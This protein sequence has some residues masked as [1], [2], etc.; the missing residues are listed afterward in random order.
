MRHKADELNDEEMDKQ[1]RNK[2]DKIDNA[3]VEGDCN[4]HQLKIFEKRISAG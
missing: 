4:C 2:N 3:I 1:R